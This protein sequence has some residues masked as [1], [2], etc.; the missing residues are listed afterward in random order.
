MTGD[1]KIGG[2]G[3]VTAGRTT[4]ICG[5][6][7]IAANKRGGGNGDIVINNRGEISIGFGAGYL[8]TRQQSR[9]CDGGQKIGDN[10]RRGA[11]W[12]NGEVDA[13]GLI[14][15]KGHHVSVGDAGVGTCEGGWAKAT[16]CQ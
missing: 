16:R 1:D 8:N 6:N 14:A 9:W 12:R 3:R 2:G 13:A 4:G 5:I 15:L 10:E 11:G 7:A